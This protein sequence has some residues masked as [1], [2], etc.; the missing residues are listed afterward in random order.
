[1]RRARREA[2]PRRRAAWLI[3]LAVAVAGTA[4][5]VLWPRG[6][7]YGDYVD[8]ARPTVVFVWSDP[9]PHHPDG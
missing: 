3:P 8:G 5:F 4:A 2:T 1:M 7:V 9:T 6:P